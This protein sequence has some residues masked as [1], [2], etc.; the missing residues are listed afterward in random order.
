M[1]VGVEEAE[2]EE[3]NHD[4]DGNKTNN[5]YTTYSNIRKKWHLGVLR[6]SATPS[7]TYKFSLTFLCMD[8]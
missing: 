1:A 2:E 3:D 7:C 6:L 8:V 5:S 4:E